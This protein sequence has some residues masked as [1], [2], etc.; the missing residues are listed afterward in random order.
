[1]L[2]EILQGAP[3]PAPVAAAPHADSRTRSAQDGLG[4][5]AHALIVH[6]QAHA[7]GNAPSTL[8]PL[9]PHI[10]VEDLLDCID[11]ADADD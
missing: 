10:N 7:A 6:E 2:N 1:M 3:Q 9:P 8:P 5:Q 11:Y 4:Q